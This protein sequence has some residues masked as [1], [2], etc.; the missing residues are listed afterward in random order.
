MAKDC[1]PNLVR[2]GGP[3][4][5]VLGQLRVAE[6]ERILGFTTR[7]IYWIEGVPEKAT[8]GHH[9]HKDLHQAIVLLRGS[10]KVNLKTPDVDYEFELTN[11]DEALVVPPG[12]WREMSNFSFDALMMVF[13]SEFYDENDYIRD[14]DSYEE[15]FKSR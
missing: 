13:A 1:E 14:W 3:A 11:P 12:F 6:P 2:L 9:A 15:F 10:A 4:H 7:R 5:N 8:R